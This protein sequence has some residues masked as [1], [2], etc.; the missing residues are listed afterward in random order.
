MSETHAETIASFHLLWATS[1][2]R[3]HRNGR[4]GVRNWVVRLNRKAQSLKEDMRWIAE[5]HFRRAVSLTPHEKNMAMILALIQAAII[6]SILQ[7]LTSLEKE[8][9]AEEFGHIENNRNT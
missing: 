6:H 1:R 5:R 3:A 8:L 9:Y 4:E 7:S 2:A